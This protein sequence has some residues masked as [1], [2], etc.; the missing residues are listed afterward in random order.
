LGQSICVAL[1]VGFLTFSSIC[2]LMRFRRTS[3]F[4]WLLRTRFGSAIGALLSLL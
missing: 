2:G 1:S 3:S 4:L